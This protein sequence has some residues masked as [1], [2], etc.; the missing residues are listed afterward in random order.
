MAT[1]KNTSAELATRRARVW[2][3][4]T[5]KGMSQAAI[6]DIVGVH[7]TTICRD[8]D[9]IAGQVAAEL[10]DVARREK[11]VQYHQLQEV[12]SEAFQAWEKSKESY[13]EIRKDATIEESVT[14]GE[15]LRLK[16]IERTGD[17]IYLNAALDAM[18]AIRDLL[19]LNEPKAFILDWKKELKDQGLDPARVFESMVQAAF[20]ELE[21]GDPAEVEEAGD[22][23]SD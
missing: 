4:R 5:E 15:K 1:K 22:G 17:V 20:S 3:L 14:V 7:Q 23:E 16:M 21:N 18:G 12:V 6:A 10:V 13:R 11:V 9:K 2:K 8:L 19:G